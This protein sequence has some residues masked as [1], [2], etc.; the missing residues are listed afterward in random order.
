MVAAIT[1]PAINDDARQQFKNPD[2]PQI[3]KSPTSPRKPPGFSPSSGD[4]QRRLIAVDLESIGIDTEARPGLGRGCGRM[5]RRFG[6]VEIVVQ[7]LNTAEEVG[8]ESPS[9][10]T[11][12]S[13]T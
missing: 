11:L 7:G 2:P 8:N 6:F 9:C 3:A 13:T 12:S 4:T 5:A 10:Q 1:N